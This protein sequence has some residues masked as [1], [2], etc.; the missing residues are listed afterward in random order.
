MGP[1]ILPIVL[2]HSERGW[3]ASTSFHGIIDLDDETLPLFARYV[4]QFEL[5]LDD[6]SDQPDEALHARAMTALGRLALYCLRHAREPWVLVKQLSRWLD[7]IRE[8]RG[9]P[10]GTEAMELIWRYIFTTTNPSDPKMLV[11]QLIE[12]VGQESEEEVMT[13]A[14]W[15][16]S[17]GRVEALRK[18]LLKLLRTRFGELPADAEQ[19]IQAAGDAQLDSWIDRVITASSLDDALAAS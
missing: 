10:G 4:P 7:L 6:I 5:L 12:V 1:A 16:R 3:K 8:V 18:T 15:L 14:D 17:E 2:H 19:R 11:E 13:V 9:A